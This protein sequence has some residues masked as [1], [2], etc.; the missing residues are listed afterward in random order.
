VANVPEMNEHTETRFRMLYERGESFVPLPAILRFV[1]D[2]IAPFFISL[3]PWLLSL[4]NAEEG[5]PPAT[6]MDRQLF[7]AVERLDINRAVRL[8]AQGADINAL[9]DEGETPLTK[10]AAASNFDFLPCE[11]ADEARRNQPDLSQD[12]R[13]DMMR[14]LLELGADVNL[15]GYEG[16]SPLTAAVLRH[17]DEVVLFLLKEGADPNH[18]H[19]HDEDPEEVSTAMY[20]AS[21]DLFLVT[22]GSEEEKRLTRICDALKD[23]GVS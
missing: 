17:E 3:N 22:E 20:Y 19:F 13:I 5:R 15:F 4:V 9:N 1:Y 6:N 10:L 11:E 23:A 18:S 7:D 16:F 2:D 21:N 8:V 14:R 12:E